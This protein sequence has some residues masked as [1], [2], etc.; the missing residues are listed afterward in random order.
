[1]QARPA[2]CKHTPHSLEWIVKLDEHGCNYCVLQI[3]G[4]TDL[5]GGALKVTGWGNLPTPFDLLVAT[6]QQGS[7][8]GIVQ[9]VEFTLSAAT[10]LD[11]SL[12]NGTSW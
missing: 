4:K 5:P 2:D 12:L 6:N 10:D 8:D 1:M 11:G 7:N 9:R 3:D